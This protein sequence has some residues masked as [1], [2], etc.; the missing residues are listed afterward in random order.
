MRKYNKYIIFVIIAIIILISF[1]MG[2]RY[3]AVIYSNGTIYEYNEILKRINTSEYDKAKTLISHLSI[4]KMIYKIKNRSL[5]NIIIN[6]DSYIEAF[7]NVYN[8]SSNMIYTNDIALTDCNSNL[9]NNKTQFK[10][11]NKELKINE[12]IKYMTNTYKRR[13][14]YIYKQLI[15]NIDK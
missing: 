5:L 13:L 7:T 6:N 14:S 9:I 11:G 2:R 8:I 15:K 1:D 12:Y 3:E 10:I 4:D